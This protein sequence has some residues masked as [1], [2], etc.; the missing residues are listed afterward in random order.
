MINNPF[1]LTDYAT[2][3]MYEYWLLSIK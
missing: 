2:S 1:I 3:T